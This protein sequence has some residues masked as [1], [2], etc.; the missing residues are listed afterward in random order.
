VQRH[1]DELEQRVI[2]RTRELSALYEVAALA[3]Q[4]LDLETILGQSL[5]Q[6]LETVAGDAGIIHLLEG[7]D[8]PFPDQTSR[9]RV[10]RL[11]VHQGILPD[12]VDEM[13]SLSA[14]GGLVG[15]VIDH[16]EPLI[17]PDISIDGRTKLVF[18]TEPRAYV[19]VPLRA[20]G[21]ALGVL[22]IVRRTDQPSLTVEELSMLTSVAD[23]LGT[24]VESIRL[25]DQAERAAVL[26]ERG[27]LA[28]ELHDSVT[29]LLYSINLFAKAGR[30]AYSQ[31]NV[32]GGNAHLTKLGDTASQAIKEM[33]L[34]L[35]ELRPRALEQQGLIGAIQH[36]LDAVEGR[37][38]VSAQLLAN[39]TVEL[40]AQVE[41]ELYHIVQEALN[42][43]LKHSE[44]TSVKV[45]IEA[46]VE[47]V[48]V[49][50]T[51]DGS[52]LDPHGASKG[53][54]MGLASMRE[55][56][57]RIG[58]RLTILS[59]PGKGTTVQ[60]SFQSNVQSASKEVP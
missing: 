50:V 31:G 9:K 59:E 41:Q 17:V 19:G 14:D 33:R 49:E 32:Q 24:V 44:A 43:A 25:R 42:N 39:T 51:D 57:E 60:F 7:V 15:W 10:L 34:L 16:D 20:G 47:G 38:G 37:A 30:D 13:R 12:A 1:A 35:Y 27:R 28:R 46:D 58:G 23:Q 40:P 3:S 48:R 22:S 4:P 45:Q 2:D 36:R 54:G 55:R 18:R 29:Q 8:N 21:R 6:V 56:A 53:G 26:E 11:L 5:D 52:G